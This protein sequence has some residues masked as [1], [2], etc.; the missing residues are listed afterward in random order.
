M[1]ARAWPIFTVNPRRASRLSLDGEAGRPR[2]RF[3]PGDP[4]PNKGLA[5]LGLMGWIVFLTIMLVAVVVMASWV[6][7]TGKE[8]LTRRT[9]QGLSFALM[10]YHQAT[11]EFPPTVASNSQLLDYLNSLPAA[12]EAV[13]AM[14][15]YVFRVTA[16]GHKEI[17]D[18]WSRPLSYVYDPASRQPELISK[19]PDNQDLTDDIYAE[20]LH[21]MALSCSPEQPQ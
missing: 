11:G 16:A 7:K 15:P 6:R 3:S 14:P 20:G 5:L 9:L 13:Q 18:G 8:Q 19:G 17:L 4:Q 12:R 1:F 21:S 10:V 2:G